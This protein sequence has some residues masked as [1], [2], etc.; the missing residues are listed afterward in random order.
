MLTAVDRL[1]T[2]TSTSLI[3]SL[4]KEIGHYSVRLSETQNW[5]QPLGSIPVK[6]NTIIIPCTPRQNLTR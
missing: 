6:D 2:T 4:Y 5:E 3:S 1:S